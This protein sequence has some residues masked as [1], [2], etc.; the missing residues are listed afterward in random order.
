MPDHTEDPMLKE[1]FDQALAEVAKLHRHHLRKGT[2]VPYLSHLLGVTALVLEDGGDEDEAI[3]ALLHDALEDCPDKISAE[4]I[5]E[6]FGPRVRE[7][8]EACTDT[9]PDHTGGPKPGWKVRKERYLEQVAG[10]H[11]NRISLADKLH[12]ARCILRDRIPARGAGPGGPKARGPGPEP[13]RPPAFAPPR[14]LS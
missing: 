12:N 4:E 11:G 5:E 13:C 6:K 2:L 10:G 9:P 14:Q 8:V 3:A 7:L 1:R